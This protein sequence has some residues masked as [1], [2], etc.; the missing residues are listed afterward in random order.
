MGVDGGTLQPHL[1]LPGKRVVQGESSL[2]RTSGGA[3]PPLQWKK[4]EPEVCVYT[5]SQAEDPG[6]ASCSVT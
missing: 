5:D 3:R 4:R 1:G 2:G 6:L